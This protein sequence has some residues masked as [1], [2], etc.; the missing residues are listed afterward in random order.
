V[1][2]DAGFPVAGMPSAGLRNSM[3][4]IGSIPQLIDQMRTEKSLVLYPRTR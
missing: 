1:N 3:Y 2:S 4:A